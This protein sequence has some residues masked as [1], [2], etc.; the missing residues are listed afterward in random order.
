M[1]AFSLRAASFSS[2]AFF[3][4]FLARAFSLRKRTRTST[5]LLLLGQLLLV[6]LLC[7]LLGQGLQLEEAHP[8][9]PVHLH[10]GPRKSTHCCTLPLHTPVKTTSVP[11]VPKLT[12]SSGQC[13]PHSNK[14]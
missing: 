2:W 3:A 13:R 10:G 6:G 4:D 8:H 7:R 1:L 12:G 9:Q 11:R 14:M 5:S